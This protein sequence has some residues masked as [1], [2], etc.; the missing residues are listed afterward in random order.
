MSRNVNDY[1]KEKQLLHAYFPFIQKDSEEMTDKLDK[2][3]AFEQ[4][5]QGLMTVCGDDAKCEGVL[6]TPYRMTKALLEYTEGYRED[7]KQHLEKTFDVPYKELVL[8]KDIEF[9]SMCEHHLAPFFGVA[10]VGYF[11]GEKITGLSK[12]ARMV[13]GYARRFQVQERLTTQIAEALEEVLAP[14]G[15]MVVVEAKHLCMC[16]RGVKKIKCRD[17][18]VGY[19]WGFYNRSDFTC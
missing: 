8:V 3:V 1:D 14:V 6:E 10:H 11:P 17:I 19:A 15:V 4:A 13:E 9:Y 5:L 16:S 7:A 18:N 12:I 2:V